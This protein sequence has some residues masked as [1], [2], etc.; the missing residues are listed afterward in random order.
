M[1]ITQNRLLKLIVSLITIVVITVSLSS[2]SYVLQL[3]FE[4]G[5]TEDGDQT[6]DIP[7]D[8]EEDDTDS[9]NTTGNTPSQS[10]SPDSN[11]TNS[12]A[13]I[14]FYPGSGSVSADN[15]SP[16]N[17]TLLSTV[18][19]RTAFGSS[20]S[21]GSGVIYSIDKATGDAYVVTNYHVVY[22]ED[23]GLCNKITLFLYG[24][25]LETYGI[26]AEFLGGSASY[27]IAV[28]KVTGSEVM[29]NSYAMAAKIGNSD[30][31][32]IFDEVIAVGNP[33]GFG[34][35]ATTGTVNVDSE[36]LSMRGSNGKAIELRVIRV[37]APIN[38]G[39]SGG[40]LYN[41]AGELIG[42]VN[43]KRIGSEI[44]NMAYAIPVN[45]AKNLADNIIYYCDG[46]ENTSVHRPL[47]GITITAKV[48]G[49]VADPVTGD[50]KK[51]EKIEIKEISSDC[52]IATEVMVGDV[53]N[54]ISVDGVE[55]KVSRLYHLIDHMLT[56]RVGSS[57]TVNLTR[58]E[59]TL[60]VNFTVPESAFTIV[61]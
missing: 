52:L 16:K 15:I 54:S 53:I 2:C 12:N 31:V 41:T 22:K 34:M 50:I 55:I 6:I 17:R 28:L 58:G 47:I 30:D 38:E 45:L 32:R 33:E 48:I 56:A 9:N 61:E 29:K 57:V 44:D 36:D 4:Y 60:D 23:Y 1:K 27:D 5:T 8:D 42:I 39:N 24:M 10:T 3:L 20:P 18:V 37:S 35:A 11:N 46:N 51:A 21:A 13:E 49:V 26:S 25:E 59:T 40:G 7:L 14:E 19:I 43:A